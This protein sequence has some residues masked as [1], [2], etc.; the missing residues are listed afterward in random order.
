MMTATYF[1]QTTRI[2]TGWHYRLLEAKMLHGLARIAFR[3]Y[4]RR[5]LAWQALRRHISTHLVY[6]RVCH[7]TKAVRSGERTFLQMTFPRLG[8]EAMQILA[9]NELHRQ[10]PIPDHPPGL[11]VLVLA[12]TK[13]CSLRCAHCFEWEALNGREHLSKDDVV[14][15]IRKFQA[16]GVATIE[17]SGGEP[18][19]RFD[20]LVSILQESDTHC[21]DFWLL[22]S[23]YRLTPQ[24]AQSLAAAGLVGLG[25]SLDHWDAAE[26]DRFRGLVGSF[27]WA[28]QAARNAQAAGMVV[29]LT[30]TA[31]REFC[32]PEHLWAYARLAREWNVPFI[33]I[34]EPRA[35]GHFA[36]QAVELGPSEI[37][38]LEEF[39]RKM[40]RDPAYRDYPVVDYYAAYQRYA[41]CSGA[42][43]RFLYVDTDGDM[44]ACP[45]C[46]HKCGSALCGTIASGM[47]NLDRASGCHAYETT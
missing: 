34:L 44:H 45:F 2:I 38:V 7:L 8:T 23:G 29:C 13:K 19:N 20:D 46:Q 28:Q 10:V 17:L 27:D 36:G 11:N 26:H 41:G 6:Q 25:L 39:V 31:I 40:Q 24:R 1:Q 18:L 15:I 42:G 14:T 33:R 5:S 22:T 35:V 32:T 12:I 21:T 43:R 9:R 30:L 4:P 16:N 3:A 37:G 47:A